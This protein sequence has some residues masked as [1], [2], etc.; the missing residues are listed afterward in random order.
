MSEQHQDE[1]D[2]VSAIFEFAIHV[3]ADVI[4][5]NGHVNNVVYVQWM[6]DAA[7]AHA[8][9]CIPRNADE[10]ADTS[11]VAR[12]HHI[13]YLLPVVEGQ[14]IVVRTWIADFRRVRSTRRYRFVRLDDQK[15]VAQGQT[16]WVFIDTHSGRPRSIPEMVQQCFQVPHNSPVPDQH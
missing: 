2:A 14:R 8:R 15:L 3:T 16:D 9:S 7:V 4:D 11:W 1:K 6:Q 13:E 10:L 12:S 5:G